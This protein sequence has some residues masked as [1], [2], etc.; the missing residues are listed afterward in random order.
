M[1]KYETES[2]FQKEAAA[3]AGNA[4][5][6][7]RQRDLILDFLQTNESRHLTAEEIA[8]GLRGQRVGKS[9]VYRTLDLLIR[10]G[11]V[12]RFFI[13]DRAS[14]CYQYAPPGGAC[15]MHYHLKCHVCGALLH[16]ECEF[17]DQVEAHIFEHH[18]FQIDNSKTV[19]YGVC[20]NCR[21]AEKPN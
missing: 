4:R 7:T 16:V 5:Y 2:Q 17:L 21:K 11:L 9:T 14:A 15:K 3:I 1:L 6:N 12:R 20:Q 10:E 13:E 18:G 8:E 19:L